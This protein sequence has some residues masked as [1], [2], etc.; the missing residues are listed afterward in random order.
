M[1]ISNTNRDKLEELGFKELYIRVIPFGQVLTK[2]NAD[3]FPVRS[4][5]SF[6]TIDGKFIIESIDKEMWR[7]INIDNTFAAKPTVY[8]ASLDELL[9]LIK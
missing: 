6:S 1:N 3:T 2:D 8:A 4:S 7:L 9:T 5:N